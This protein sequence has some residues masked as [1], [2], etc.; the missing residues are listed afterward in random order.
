MSFTLR[1]AAEAYGIDAALIVS[2][3]VHALAVGI[4]LSPT[5]DEGK[6]I[7]NGIAY[8]ENKECCLSD[9]SPFSAAHALFLDRQQ[10]T[11]PP[12][13]REI[14]PP[15]GVQMYLSNPKMKAR[16]II[17]SRL[18]SVLM[19]GLLAVTVSLWLRRFATVR[20]SRIGLLLTA[21]CPTLLAYASIAGA[22]IH[23]AAFSFLTLFFWTRFAEKPGNKS[24]LLVG[25][26]L[27]LT[28]LTK[29]SAVL[30]FIAL[31]LVFGLFAADAIVRTRQSRLQVFGRFVRYGALLVT[32]ALFVLN[33]GY[34]FKGTFSTLSDMTLHSKQFNRAQS[35]WIGAIPLP[36]PSGLVKT[37]DFSRSL[38]ESERRKELIPGILFGK[39]YPDGNPWFYLALLALK[40]S[41]ILMGLF[42]LGIGVWAVKKRRLEEGA[43]LF[44]YPIFLV[45][46]LSAFDVFNRGIRYL[47]PLFPLFIVTA[48]YAFLWKRAKYLMPA[49]GIFAV[50]TVLNFPNYL[51]FF[52][53][54]EYFFAKEEMLVDSNL[55]WGQLDHLVA[56][57]AAAHGIKRV[58][59]RLLQ[60]YPI[61]L[62]LPVI[63]SLYPQPCTFYLSK[64]QK[65]F[66]KVETMFQLLKPPDRVLGGLIEVFDVTKE[67]DFKNK[68]LN[69]WKISKPF[70]F[71][72]I[73]EK[74]LKLLSA[75]QKY[76]DR[77]T[78]FGHVDLIRLLGVKSLQ[79][80][81]VIAHSIDKVRGSLLLSTTAR[82]L[83]F[84]R[85]N[86]TITD[87]FTP[88]Q[89]L[90]FYQYVT[91]FAVPETVSALL[92]GVKDRAAFIAGYSAV[93]NE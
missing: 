82:M 53:V 74:Q 37:I 1:K 75:N 92:C 66:P 48:S 33:L 67:S 19:L 72:E 81:C 61:R 60:P 83:L 13:N 49:L 79:G 36:V 77:T 84:N 5:F 45:S 65:K 73:T 51:A 80:K 28:L 8:L 27:G 64:T 15:D 59:P 25:V 35:S 70:D 11:L 3:M 4:V 46:Y 91:D 38:A 22:D 14:T 7:I 63:E 43:A 93:P 29:F 68:F 50:S 32:V 39:P 21:F 10:M 9:E 89:K 42:F 16:I 85:K 62:G 56:E 54:S 76:T 20:I 58:C 24:A 31:F 52:N 47:L 88:Y 57:D 18:S 17:L 6:H 44:V 69:R 78:T 40:P 34:F 12:L 86:G 90:H 2:A 30:F 41:T 26:F 87:A 71:G 55:D 23:L